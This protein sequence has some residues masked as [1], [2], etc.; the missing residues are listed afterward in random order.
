MGENLRRIRATDSELSR[1]IAEYMDAG[2]RVPPRL[3]AEVTHDS[4]LKMSSNQDILFDGLM[5]GMDEVEAQKETFSE[6]DLPMPVIIFL[7]LDEDT[8]VAR[9][10][11]RRICSGCGTRYTLATHST[12]G[13][14]HTPQEIVACHRC[15]GSVESRHDDTPA[16]IRQRLE[17]YHNDTLPVVDYFRE[18][19]TVIDIDASPSIEEVT[20]DII[21]K[22]TAYYHSVGR[23]IKAS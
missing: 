23:E 20:K 4:L 15:G 11:H 16:A 1:E 13:V 9:L 21:S 14:I 19:G 7:N 6:L 8:A 2:K 12:D 18:H 22:V 10:S 5:R 17:W 3:I